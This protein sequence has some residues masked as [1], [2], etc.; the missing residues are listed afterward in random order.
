[1]VFLTQNYILAGS[2]MKPWNKAVT[3]GFLMFKLYCVFFLQQPMTR[4]VLFFSWFNGSN[5]IS[6]P[7]SLGHSWTI[8]SCLSSPQGPIPVHN[9]KNS[10]RCTHCHV[11]LCTLQLFKV[12]WVH[13][14]HLRDYWRGKKCSFWFLYTVHVTIVNPP[15]KCLQLILLWNIWTRKG[16]GPD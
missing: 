10:A 15:Q 5:S 1:M 11:F 3:K 9:Y 16:W 6:V 4:L 7:D 13:I 8:H 12:F 14:S 2:K